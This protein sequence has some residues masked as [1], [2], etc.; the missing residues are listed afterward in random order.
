MMHPTGLL[1][2]V[3]SSNANAAPTVAVVNPATTT[4]SPVCTLTSLADWSTTTLVANATLVR[5]FGVGDESFMEV[6]ALPSFSHNTAPA[7]PCVLTRVP[8][9]TDFAAVL[10]GGQ[11]VSSACLHVDYSATGGDGVDFAVSIVVGAGIYHVTPLGEILFDAVAIAGR[12]A[13]ELELESFVFASQGTCA[14]AAAV[15]FF[16]VYSFSRLLFATSTRACFR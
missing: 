4:L 5:V 1:L 7:A 16:R 6:I 3:T 8:L 2:A 9:F 15:F 11:R 14:V 13:T 10:F 12:D